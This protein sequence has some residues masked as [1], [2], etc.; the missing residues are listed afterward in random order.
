MGMGVGEGVVGAEGDGGVAFDVG[1]EGGGVFNV[2]GEGGNVFIVGVV[3]RG[4]HH[5]GG[6]GW[7]VRNGNHQSIKVGRRVGGVGF[8]SWIN[9]PRANIRRGDSS[10][11]VIL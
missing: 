4:R 2:G 10:P 11:E 8:I 6:G 7:I 5:G 3:Y 9:L 1:G